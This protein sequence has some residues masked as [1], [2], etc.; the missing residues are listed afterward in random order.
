MPSVKANVTPVVI[1]WAR[2]SAGFSVV[3]A[4]KKIGRSVDDINAWE[5]GDSKPTIAQARKASKVYKRPLAVFYLPKPPKDFSTLRDFRKL[6]TDFPREF[7]SNL[8]FL[9]RQT[10]ERQMW[11]QEY[12]VEEGYSTLEFIGSGSISDNPLKV[13]KSIRNLLGV[14]FSTISNCKSRSEALNIWVKASEN[15][16]IFVFQSG[17]MQYEKI[18]VEEARGFALADE[19]APFVF[20]NA[21]DAKVAQIFT[22]IH[23]IAHLWINESGVSNM[24][25]R[26]RA[27]VGSDEVEVFCNQVAAEVILPQ[28]DFSEFWR[29]ID[30][31]NEI[32]NKIEN[33]SKYFK[34]SKTVIARRLLNSNVINRKRYLEFADQFYQEWLE[35]KDEIKKKNASSKGGPHMYLMKVINNGRQ[36]SRMVLGAY[37]SGRLSGRD[38]SAILGVKVN[39][40]ATYASYAGMKYS[41]GSAVK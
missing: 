12:L 28:K 18:E 10:H 9:I 8:R 4:A 19:Y 14:S 34:V 20:L 6:P 41:G 27:L 40:L 29:N 23:E 26:G 32:E 38:T 16:G 22:L 7:S 1:K 5:S 33:S 11:L 25:D 24:Y 39:G 2:E 21:Q 13:A 31:E 3:D 30:S 37:Q 15:I 35:Y 36:F 17:N